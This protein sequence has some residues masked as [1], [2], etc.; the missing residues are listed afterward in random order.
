MNMRMRIGTVAV[1]IVTVGLLL[2][3]NLPAVSVSNAGGD[4]EAGATLFKKKCAMCHAQD[5]SGN[6]KMAKMLKVEIRDLGSA[7]VQERTD[8]DIAKIVKEGDGKMKP[9][10]GLSED[11]IAN[12]IAFIRTLKK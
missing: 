10:E 11:D 2:T 12:V 8:E 5:G 9:V 1:V 6:E 4:A 3:L 7:E